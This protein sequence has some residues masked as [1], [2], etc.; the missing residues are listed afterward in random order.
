M[1]GGQEAGTAEAVGKSLLTSLAKRW[2]AGTS[3]LALATL[4]ASLALVL[5]G[6]AA[7]VRAADGAA[8]AT[9]AAA[10]PLAEEFDEDH[11]DGFPDPFEGMNRG[12]LRFNLG[13][14]RWIFDPV[15]RG[16]QFLVPEP[17]RLAVRRV[18]ANL[19]APVVFVNDVLQ[20][21]WKGAGTTTARFVLNT[22]VG[23]A[24]IFDPA[25]GL[26]LKEHTADFGQTLALAGV[27]SGPYL[28][29]PI[30]GPTTVRDSVGAVVDFFFRPMTYVLGPADQLLYSTTFSGSSGIATR[31]EHAQALQ[32][33]K[34]SSVDYYAALRNAYY[35]DRMAQI[36]SRQEPPHALVRQPDTGQVPSDGLPA[37]PSTL[38]AAS[39]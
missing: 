16:Y 5:T 13:L 29:L 30:F 37:A 1:S 7:P 14:D 10:D 35:Q 3:L 15:T 38:H 8:V 36:W 27:H 19:N 2:R 23:V 21:E 4:T 25:A 31:D 9:D 32:A 34:E 17:G 20:A 39:R 12:T 24:G 18:L 26:G 6:W 11:V 33:L 22:T 28:I